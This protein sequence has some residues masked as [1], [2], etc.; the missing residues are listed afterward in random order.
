[1]S[2]GLLALLA[3][4]P[5][6]LA[7]VLLIGL[8]WPAKHAMPRVYVL[9][10]CVGLFAWDMRVNRVLASTLQGLLIN[11]GLLWIIFAG[12]SFTISYALTGV[13]LGAKF[14]TLAGGLIGLAI[15]TSAARMGFLLPKTTWDFARRINGRANS[16]ALSR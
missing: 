10:S 6:M 8:R 13:F 3:F 1:M 5:I 12:I 9:T 16:W 2:T 7:A 14:P 11:L 4:P 15:V